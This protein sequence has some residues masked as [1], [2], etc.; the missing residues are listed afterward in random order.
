MSRPNLSPRP[1]SRQQEGQR[2]IPRLNQKQDQ[3][4]L[5]DKAQ[6]CTMNKA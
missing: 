6:V 1:I 2:A 4:Q 5:N 3:G